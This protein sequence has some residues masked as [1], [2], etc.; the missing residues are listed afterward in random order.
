MDES[1]YPIID[2]N[3]ILL[4]RNK[5][6]AFV[7]GAAGFLGSFLVDKL[8]EKDIQVIG[9]D[10]LSTGKKE[11]LEE[12]IKR[13]DFHFIEQSIQDLD[14]NL[15]RLD[16]VFIATGEG[17]D[18]TGFLKSVKN[19][20]MSP[21]YLLISSIDL[22]DKGEL[23]EQLR[24][25]ERSEAKLA[26]FAAENRLNARILRLGAV[27]GPRMHFRLKDPLIK[28]IR[29]NLSGNLAK[30]SPLEF[31]SR[32]L[33]VED[34]CELAIKSMLAGSTA[35]RIFDGVA[36]QP[37]K[38]EE[39]KQILL[40]PVWYEERSFTPSDLP[41][42]STPNLVKTQ[43]FLN[44][45]PRVNLV[46]ALK[47]TLRYFIDREID[48][49]EPSPK[50]AEEPKFSEVKRIDL[51]LIR[52]QTKQEES[53][54]PEQKRSR[55]NFK[56]GLSFSKIYLVLATALI[57]YALIWP[58]VALGW[59]ILTFRFQLKEAE[60]NL[61]AGEFDKSLANI[62]QANLGVEQAKLILSSV[63]VLRQADFLDEKFQLA[64]DLLKLA[65][66][67]T[68][69]AENAILGIQS[70]YQALKA[71]IGESNE[72]PG[73]FF[74]NANLFLAASDQSF[75]K[76]S[77]LLLDENFQA[78]TPN[79][80]KNKL[81]SLKIRILSMQGMV[82]KG[83]AAATLLPQVTAFGGEKSYLF[84]LQ[85]NMELR[86]GGGFIGSFAKVD[87]AGGKLKK[88]LVNDIYAI[89]GLLKNHVEPP[90]EIKEDLGQK[91]YFLRDSNWEADFP[92]SAKQAEWFFTKETGERLDGVVALDVSAMEQLLE[93]VGP[94]SLA[95][96]D[97]TISA[98]NLFEKA[99]AHSEVSFF[100]GSQSKRNFLTSLTNELFN[101][102]FFLPKQNWPG[103]VSALGQSLEEKHI[104][105]YLD[106]PTLF[107]YLVSENWANSLPQVAEQSDPLS[108]KLSDIMIAVEANLGANKTNYYLD[109]SYNLET[110]LG[111]EGEVRHRLRITY[112]N[113]SPSDVWP[114]GIYKNRFRIYL[115]FGAKLLRA[116]WGE[117]NLTKDVA[118]F[119]DYGRSGYSLLLELQPKEQKSL[120]L[121]Y[122][123][124]Q[125]LKFVSSRATYRLDIIKQAGTLTDPF[126]W[127]LVYPLNY[128]LISPEGENQS[129]EVNIS[130]DLS[131]DRSFE[132]E[133][134]K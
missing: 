82:Q 7:V 33:F 49:K 122:E 113:K 28:L 81:E 14:L 50:Q 22:Y 98:D 130:T 114:G 108:N 67:S 120:V 105:I 127:R 97:E 62:T 119:V 34:A 48:I 47:E 57:V 56:I 111:K 41:P 72:D 77:A 128:Q 103:I 15:S 16:Y 20:L 27:F 109:R 5:P 25:L 44:W 133:F 58:V 69:G 29:Q 39:V 9:V 118:P 100:P 63:Q 86:P 95:D 66:S 8:L 126:E 76:A 115:P 129:Q 88:L 4:A 87:F 84:L 43:K 32:A 53:Q 31:S 93:V 91:D 101:K 74:E 112:V 124:A 123:I 11:H 26:Q 121:D 83:R 71:V 24:W 3:S 106:D 107:S 35:Q 12:A 70:L 2:K 30:E 23:D 94:L 73:K 92:T 37:V 54:Q 96:Y 132:V 68:E 79:F 116:L 18:I 40:D 17:W 89:D 38:I 42:W 21:R 75:S 117:A 52:Q 10:N 90:K 59:G 104:S 6:V 19:K 110:V 131:R 134:K 36:P 13:K 60:R 99:I 61:A 46:K 51:G 64:D 1:T 45:K 102:I 80:L 55:A 65:N 78:E 125:M 85:N